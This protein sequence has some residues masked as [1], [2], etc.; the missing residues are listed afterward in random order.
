[1]SWKQE[2]DE[3][4]QT[5][6]MFASDT[7]RDHPNP[8]T[9]SHLSATE[10]TI[11]D[12]LKQVVEPRQ[13]FSPMAFPTSERDEI[14]RRVANFKT[15]QQEVARDRENYYLQMRTTILSSLANRD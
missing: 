13:V 5:T 12:T 9:P 8:H 1:M 10:Q 4:I 14:Q 15:H 11:L 3:L 6:M 7:Q 2:L